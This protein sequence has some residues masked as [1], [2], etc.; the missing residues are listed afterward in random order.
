LQADVAAKDAIKQGFD[1]GVIAAV[2]GS[3]PA[4]RKSMR[5]MVNIMERGKKNARFAVTNRPSD[6]V[7]DS[8]MDRVRTVQKINRD[9]GK[10]LDTVAKSLKGQQVEFQ[11]A[12]NAFINDL[13]DMGISVTDDLKLNF[14]GS[15]IEGLAGP[16]R[17]ITQVFNRMKTTRP[18]D[19]FDLHRMKRFIDEQV[20]FGKNAEGLA[21]RSEAVL[22][23]LR[24]NLDQTLDSNFPE[25]DAVNTQYSETIGALDALQDVAGRKMDLTGPN[26][27]KA[28]GTLMR[29]LMSNAQSR[30]T[31]LDSIN[32]IEDV[33]NKFGGKFKDDLLS[34]VLFVDELDSVFG[35]VARTS[36]Q[37]QIKQGVGA[38]IE[39]KTSPVAAALRAG[40]AVVDKARGIN[41]EG[42]FKSI[43]KLLQ[44]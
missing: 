11:P 36:F 24:R 22:K 43:K 7:G 17:A 40:G 2:K 16:E 1:E 27:E 39:V 21:G 19:A 23:S 41:Q 6:V 5:K 37:G 14:S 18:P 3:S 33:A 20:T 8:L 15:D 31:L 26:A 12:V 42:A 30:V 28:T 35:P 4:D 34:Q 25:Y 44:Q 9:A 10:R 32:Q 13:G 29:R 38:A